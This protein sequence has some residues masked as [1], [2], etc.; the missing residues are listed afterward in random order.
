MPQPQHLFDGR[1]RDAV[2]DT[3]ASHGHPVG[4]PYHRIT[5]PFAGTGNVS[6]AVGVG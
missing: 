6:H 3:G 4:C 5:M 1:M 2:Q